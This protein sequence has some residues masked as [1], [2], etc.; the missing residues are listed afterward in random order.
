MDP[1]RLGGGSRSGSV[2]SMVSD[3]SRASS[4]AD[5]STSRRAASASRDLVLGEV[6]R[7][8]LRLAFVRRHLAE[9]REQ[10]RDRALLAERCD[11]HRFEGGFVAG[12]GDLVEDGL[13]ERCE[14]GHGSILSQKAAGCGRAGA[15]T[16]SKKPVMRGIPIPPLLNPYLRAQYQGEFDWRMRD[17]R[18]ILPG[19]CGPHSD[20]WV[21]PRR[22]P[23]NAPP[24][25]RRWT[26]SLLR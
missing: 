24:N 25:R 26:T 6:D 17:V 16:S 22:R 5:F 1:A 9:R 4:A 8:A 3:A 11:A 18:Q 19:R 2:T 12:G 13:F 20:A 14:V 10:R 7:R 21:R 23:N 15:K